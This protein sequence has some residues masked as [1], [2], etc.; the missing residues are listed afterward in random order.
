MLAINAYFVG[1][2]NDDAFFILGARSLTHGGFLDLSRPGHPPLLS[3]MP[4]TSLLYLP[5]AFL[6]SQKLIAYQVW[7]LLVSVFTVGLAGLLLEETL[8]WSVVPAA[9]FLVA[10]NPLMLS[11]SAAV[12]SDVPY[13]AATLLFFL[14]LHRWQKTMNLKRMVALS[15]A[16]VAAYYFRPMGFL[17]SVG[18]VVF[19]FYS[20]RHRLALGSIAFT[21]V[22]I[23]A[24]LLRNYLIRG[25]WLSY[26]DQFLSPFQAAFS[27]QDHLAWFFNNEW[28]YAQELYGRT[29]LRWPFSSSPDLWIVIAT[30][31]GLAVSLVGFLD[32]KK[33]IYGA[34]L[35]GYVLAYLGVIGLWRVYSGR[36]L[37]PMLPFAAYYFLRGLLVL[38]KRFPKKNVGW[39]AALL[40]VVFALKPTRS[41]LHA[42]LQESNPIN[43]PPMSVFNWVKRQTAPE[44]IF[45]VGLEARFHLYTARACL[46]FPFYQSED[47]VSK[48]CDANGI[49]YIL[50]EN[51]AFL[52]K[53]REEMD[54]FDKNLLPR[55]QIPR[56]WV[57]VYQSS[58]DG[59]SVFRRPLT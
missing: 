42:S 4:G 31:G 41:I 7:A 51:D 14:G 27:I 59:M 43:T 52:L 6:A 38:T 55:W 2:F 50:I 30:V 9:F 28:A 47:V 54:L 18:L 46:Q 15:S 5:V 22:A 53:T 11:L 48:W 56:G 34:V 19:L 58:Y 13:L 32:E 25:Y 3:Y 20:R 1:F 29:F 17:L 12:L 40:V 44:D 10:L 21:F 23:F 35:K 26:G 33:S 16:A 57:M 24:F 37:L 45:A 39:A 49:Q 36:Y 8:E